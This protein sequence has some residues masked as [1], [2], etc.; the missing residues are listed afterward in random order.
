MAGNWFKSRFAS[1]NS[2]A[3]GGDPAEKESSP[4]VQV[5][6]A[7]FDEVVL[8]A[9]LPVLVDFWAPWCMPCRMLAPTVEEIAREYQGRL[10][11]AKLNTDENPSTPGKFG[12]MGIPT[13]ILFKDGKEVERVVGV[14]PK[15][16]LLKQFATH[17]QE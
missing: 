3:S 8:K 15:Q 5:K 17:L 9:D 6:D 1:S 4:V 7:N 14:R 11:V 13:L 12:I 10:I 2:S 16:A